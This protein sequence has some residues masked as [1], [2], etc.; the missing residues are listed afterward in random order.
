[1][2]AAAA[3]LPEKIDHLLNPGKWE[4]G[5][6]HLDDGQLS[7]WPMMD[8]YTTSDDKIVF[9]QAIED[10]FWLNFCRAIGREDLFNDFPKAFEDRTGEPSHKLWLIL[11]DVFRSRTR[12]EWNE[13]SAAETS[14]AAPSIPSRS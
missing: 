12:D 4:R 11:R 6:T 7:M 8:I 2:D 9:F 10:K 1:M 3:W 13:L 5:K 14:P